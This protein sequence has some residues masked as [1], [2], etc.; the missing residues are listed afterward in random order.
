MKIMTRNF[1]TKEKV[2]LV[3]LAVMLVGL[4]YYKLVYQTITSKVMTANADAATLQSELDIAQA[5][6]TRIQQM[7]KEMQGIRNTG[8]VSKMG[9]YNSSKPETTFL[10]RVLVGVS[11]YSISFEDVTRDGDQ[12]R[13]NFNLQYKVPKYSQAEDVMQEL[14]A[15]EYRCLVSDV[16]CTVDDGG[17]TTVSLT[18][19]FYETMVGG[20]ADSALPK[21]DEVEKVDLDELEYNY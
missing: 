2:L 6:E 14:T 10:N 16:N 7:E 9:S 5:R 8:I 11:D 18:G 21:E 13:R 4:I 17:V 15:G 1:S 12:I 19:T 3:L 20:K